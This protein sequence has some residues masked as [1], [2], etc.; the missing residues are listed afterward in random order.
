MVI[1]LIGN[2]ND[3][4]SRR[5]VST[6]EGQSFAAENGLFFMETSAKTASNV[7]RA[8]VDTASKIHDRIKSGELDPSNDDHGIKL[9]VAP[10]GP[11]GGG[12]GRGGAV[13]LGGTKGGA[14]GSGSG[15][16]GGGGGCC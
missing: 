2:K 1:M 11:A 14:G 16:S 13:S 4:D 9:G 12:G 15:S 3:M 10:G 8:F 6:E 5:K 7:E